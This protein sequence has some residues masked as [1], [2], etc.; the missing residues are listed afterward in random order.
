MKE[1]Q[2]RKQ[3]RK[4]VA[5]ADLA[6]VT[7]KMIRKEVEET[8]NWPIGTIKGDAGLIVVFKDALNS[9][10]AVTTN[11]DAL[12]V[13]TI[14]DKENNG[15]SNNSVGQKRKRVVEH[16]DVEDDD[17]NKSKDAFMHKDHE[18]HEHSITESESNDV[19]DKDNLEAEIT[20]KLQGG[21]A[22]KES[23]GY[24]RQQ[25]HTSAKHS[26]SEDQVTILQGWLHKCGIRKKVCYK[27][28]SC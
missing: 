7:A 22:V 8:L 14:E 26:K 18:Q 28:S 15:K 11:E 25:K 24:K 3:T 10:L 23:N 17:R 5:K 13:A 27:C 16:S 6:V 19:L 20:S 2:L 21:Q 9:A 1:S 4:C 12:V